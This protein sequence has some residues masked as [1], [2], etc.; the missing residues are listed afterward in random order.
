MQIFFSWRK[1]HWFL[2]TLFIINLLGTI[3]GF[4]WYHYQL[5]A[6]KWNYLIFVPD[7]PSA[8]LFF[9]GVLFLFLVK[10]KSPLLEALAAIT[11]FKYGIW[12]V[13]MIIWGAVLDPVGFFPS[14][15][16][17][18]YMLMIS[19]FGM[20]VQAL[21]YAPFF[22]YRY[23]DI[24]IVSVWTLLND[25][26]DYGLDIHPWLSPEVETYHSLVGWFTLLLS[27]T[28]IILFSLFLEKRK[29]GNTSN[30]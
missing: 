28:S 27:F 24:L 20:A 7:S 12:A 9:T 4:Y 15:T 26:L 8:S 29:T 19:H 6:T 13:S 3:Y 11:L 23:K 17:E 5:E 2:W 1:E 22:V 18:H 16:W 21:L 14:L 25:A 30:L 10:K